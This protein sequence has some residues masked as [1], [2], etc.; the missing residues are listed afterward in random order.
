VKLAFLFVVGSALLGAD[1]LGNWSYTVVY[2]GPYQYADNIGYPVISLDF[3]TPTQLL[4]NATETITDF[5]YCHSPVLSGCDS[6]TMTAIGQNTVQLE[7][8]F[9]SDPEK[10]KTTEMGY[11]QNGV[12]VV[13]PGGYF[14]TSDLGAH[15]L[16]GFA[17]PPAATPEPQYLAL[18]GLLLVGAW[19]FKQQRHWLAP[20]QGGEACR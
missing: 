4:P 15:E 12:D 2:N 20:Q 13:T 6:L 3:S 14:G 10:T 11:F 1:S 17:D 9:W 5:S 8:L 16:F 18:A 7:F 19:K